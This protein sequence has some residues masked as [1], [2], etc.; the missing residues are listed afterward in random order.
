MR[1]GDRRGIAATR[2]A[3]VLAVWIAFVARGLCLRG[4]SSLLPLAAFLFAALPASAVEPRAVY[5]ALRAA[6]PQGKAVAVQNLALERDVFR[7]QFTSG[8]FQFLTPVEGRTVGAVF[9]G[10]GN[11]ELRPAIEIERRHLAFV[12]G[13]KT[14]ETLSEPFQSLVLLFT[15]ATAA[16]IER[17]GTLAATPPARA[18]DIYESFF[19]TQRKE[20]KKNLQIRLLQD[21][22]EAPDS[23]HGVFLAYI[24]GKKYPAALAAEDPDGLDW[25]FGNIGGESSALYVIHDRD[26]GLWYCSSSQADVGAGKP[27]SPRPLAHALK[28]VIDTTARR[29]ENISGTTTIW[30]LPLVENLRVL[31][32]HLYRK[33]RLK[34]ATFA[35]EGS[36]AWAPAAFVQEDKDEDAD[37]A[38][39]FPAPRPQSVVR[40]RL[41]YEGEGVL[42]D[43]GYDNYFVGARTNWYPN[44]GTFTDL[45]SF[46]LTYR[47]PKGLRVISV[48]RLLEERVEGNT[49]ISVWKQD[50]PIRVAGF[51]YGKF[52][53]LER[54]DAESGVTVSIY[55][56]EGYSRGSSDV[57]E[58]AATADG[59]N[60]ARVATLYFGPLP[61]PEV[62][63]T[64]QAQYSFGQ[65]WPALIY[66][67]SSVSG[68]GPSLNRLSVLT[69]D[70]AD[71]VD[72]VGSHEFAHQWW[73]HLVGWA[74]YRD[75]WLSEGFAEFTS[76]LVVEHAAG[77]EGY[78]RFWE[79]ARTR[80][81]EKPIKAFVAN[82]EA[83]PI[84]QG[85]RLATWRNWGAYQTM[86]YT[87]GAYVLHMLRM[88]MRDWKS[89][90]PDEKFIETMKDFA[91]TYAGK[92]PS[93]RDFQ[94]VVEGHMT[95]A[96]NAAGDGKMDWFFKQWV[97][98]TDIPRYR[99]KLDISKQGDGQYRLT[100]S[101]SQEGVS[102]DFRGFAHVYAVFS[103]G[104]MAR[105]GG[106]S[107]VGNTTKPLDATLRLSKEPK[108]LLLNAFHDVLSRD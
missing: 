16:E 7:F 26:R 72:R 70:W 31:P 81:I 94:A 39:L 2:R 18:G 20:L 28:Y 36:E 77:R 56:S 5:D 22:L 93:T 103:N 50:R 96:M 107:L 106:L 69:R 102:N 27:S 84:I 44:L 21:V 88:L 64:E 62:S 91:S 23:G 10:Q 19:K 99:Q 43:A 71:F 24:D 100:G 38:V 101:I 79:R 82:D 49:Q 89:P 68:A 57:L 60:T 95:P 47:I 85:W 65:S 12:T 14:L 67:P 41:A 104:E 4:L 59:V 32:V 45:S 55:A 35:S 37:A 25:L 30:S 63:V 40:L 98:G 58:D 66:L 33:L 74:S 1:S 51:N 76:A 13:E 42:E 3:A 86:I 48:G 61:E 75:Q 11:F 34:E 97:Y 53:K 78:S 108:R 9:V 54:K 80:I 52:R 92:N 15:D 83:G 17:H 87:K 6:R 46:E 8:T 73:G 90:R 29:N 105:L